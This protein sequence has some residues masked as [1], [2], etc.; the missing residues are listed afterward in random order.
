MAPRPTVRLPINLYMY[1]TFVRSAAGK[2]SRRCQLSWALAQ[3]TRAPPMLANVRK[4]A[5]ID[6]SP[7]TA[8]IGSRKDELPATHHRQHS[9]VRPNNPQAQYTPS[10]LVLISAAS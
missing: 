10:V 2:G 8:M 6:A 5:T 1:F 9:T 7:P 4:P 3:P